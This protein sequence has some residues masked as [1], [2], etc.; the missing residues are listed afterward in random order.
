MSQQNT[1]TAVE[2]GISRFKWF[3]SFSLALEYALSRLGDYSNFK[4]RA[5]YNIIDDD[6]RDWT[7]ES[8]ENHLEANGRVTLQSISKLDDGRFSLG[9]IVDFYKASY[10]D[11]KKTCSS[12]EWVDYIENRRNDEN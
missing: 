6:Y 11:N 4:H 2:I 12:R 1:K 8:L 7:P 10:L 3:D 5:T 9:E